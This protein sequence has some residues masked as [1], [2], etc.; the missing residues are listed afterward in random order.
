MKAEF[1]TLGAPNKGLYLTLS[2]IGAS[3]VGCVSEDKN[4][5]RVDVIVG[6]ETPEQLPANTAFMGG[7]VG[8]F[9]NRIA[10]GQY[11]HDGETHQLSINDG[12]NH[13]HGGV[14]GIHM[15][16]W[17][18]V[19]QSDDEI[20]FA[21]TSPDGDDGYPGTLQMQV[22]YRLVG[23]DAFTVIYKA[24]T[25]KATPVNIAQHAYWNLTGDPSLQIV[26]HQVQSSDVIAFLEVSEEVM[27]TGSVIDVKGTVFDFTNSRELTDGL[28]SGEEQ[29]QRAGG[30]DHCLVFSDN[31]APSAQ[32]S[33]QFYEPTS[34]RKLEVTTNMPA[35]QLYSGNFLDGSIVGKCGNVQYRTGFCVETQHY[36]D[37]VNFDHFPSPILNPGEKY[38]H[39]IEYRLTT[40]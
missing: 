18:V 26:K 13:L 38:E 14:K 7:T 30:Y 16:I 21:Y 32:N 20:I 31:V 10:K 33:I 37:A 15:E 1:Y 3:L 12:A 2:N 5:N 27:P 34:G 28:E 40:A 22:I 24:E 9:A 25:D 36:P 11:T 8:R 29:I 6:P 23:N 19:S 35:V 39:I 17:D 4:G